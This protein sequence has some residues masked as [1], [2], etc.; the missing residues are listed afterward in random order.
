MRLF[1]GAVG[2]C[3]FDFVVQQVTRDFERVGAQVRGRGTWAGRPPRKLS[4]RSFNRRSTSLTRAPEFEHQPSSLGSSAQRRS[5]LQMRVVRRGLPS[6]GLEEPALEGEELDRGAPSPN[7]LDPSQS[8]S[9]EVIDV[10]GR[11]PRS[12]YRAANTPGWL[13]GSARRRTSRISA[14]PHPGAAG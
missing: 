10:L 3:G 6:R 1:G 9:D 14:P 4:R 2:E 13:R 8:V 11:G 5:R 12:P 7:L